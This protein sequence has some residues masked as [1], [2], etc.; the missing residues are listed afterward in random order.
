[1][2]RLFRP[3]SARVRPMSAHDSNPANIRTECCTKEAGARGARSCPLAH[4]IRRLTPPHAL[5][6]RSEPAAG[7][8]LKQTPGIITIESVE[9][10]SPFFGLVHPG[11]L[12]H[13]VCA[14]VDGCEPLDMMGAKDV[15]DY[16]KMFI[17]ASRLTVRVETLGISPEKAPKAS[18]YTKAARVASPQSCTHSTS[19]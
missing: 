19:T 18:M 9:L 2:P 8:Y 14:E 5:K 11:D 17:A 12:I 16:A 1:M 4:P 10:S 7:V 3:G 15:A 6:S 13:S